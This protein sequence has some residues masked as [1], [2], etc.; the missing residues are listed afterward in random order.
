M[1][2][3][4]DNIDAGSYTP[5]SLN[6]VLRARAEAWRYDPEMERAAEVFARGENLP[7]AVRMSLGYYRDG[8][9]AA[10]AMGRDVS[11]PATADNLSAAYSS[12][13]KGA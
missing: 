8:K 3:Y 11:A 12:L 10:A 1:N 9:K 5:E 6:R 13:N 2:G 4:A 7:S